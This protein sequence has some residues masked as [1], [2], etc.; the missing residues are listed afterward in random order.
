M[1][2]GDSKLTN[3]LRVSTG[4]LIISMLL[5]SLIA[6]VKMRE[7]RQLSTNVVDQSVPLLN[8]VRD[9]RSD[10]NRTSSSLKSYLLFGVEPRM[11][12]RYH[13][14]RTSDWQA[15]HANMKTIE[16]LAAKYD[17][18]AVNGQL[19]AI[20]RE[21]Q[22][23]EQ[24]EERVEK[25]A[26]GQGSEAAGQAYDLLR[27]EIADHEA[28]LD[29]LFAQV[30]DE[31]MK[32]TSAEMLQLTNASR[33]A[34][35][36]LWVA[37]ILGALFGW[38]FSQMLAS[39]IVRSIL[40][41]AS[42]AEAIAEGD[43]TGEELQMDSNDEV[44]SLACSINRMQENLRSMIST[45][46]E[47]A[48][49]IHD[50]T[51]SLSE[52]AS[53]NS[54]RIEEQTLQ[55]HQ[56]AASMQ[57]MSISIAEVSRHAQNAAISAKEAAGTAREGGS[58]VEQML[59]SMQSISS[60]VRETAATVQRLGK[61]SEQIIR[62]VNVIEEIAQKTNLLALN[63]AIEAAR[64]GEQGRGFAV[65]AGEVRRLAES[66]R[67][68]TSEIAQMIQGVQ[69][70]TRGAVQAMEA[71]TATVETGVQTTTQAGVALRRIIEMADQV[72][73]MIAQI[74]IAASQQ[75]CAA[76]QS[77]ANLDVINK[78]S[79][80]SAA[81]IPTTNKMVTSVESGAQRL[82]EHIGHFQLED[83]QRQNSSRAP[84]G[85]V[86]QRGLARHPVPGFGD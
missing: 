71:G 10:V 32:A 19:S 73:G 9:L 26:V 5:G 28:K 56:A 44:T 49:S 85:R 60:A 29:G 70:H 48:G 65:V 24:A 75:S 3:K 51:R 40:Q 20:A 21:A 83:T 34:N 6:Y 76:E 78:L 23:M 57:E 15:A 64:A 1:K 55:T 81:S 50:D 11:A 33:A 37:T 31:Q 80:E 2:F 68:A 47:I 35:M 41:V 38:F 62:I 17:M 25:M 12:A 42:R 82:R 8:S 77:S 4:V 61:E 13:D 16:A 46:V 72:D 52:G 79:V 27:V 30:I 86:D 36:V 53:Q 69:M 74:A 7:V 84:R 45:M 39:R 43:L 66:T 59:G 54:H 22:A 14:E 18:G 63:A 67:D 58:I